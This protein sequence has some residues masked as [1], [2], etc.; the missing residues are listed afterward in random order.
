MPE[1]LRLPGSHRIKGS[2]EQF[3]LGCG[4]RTTI[5]SDSTAPT[6]VSAYDFRHRLKTF[7]GLKPMS[8][9]ARHGDQPQ[10]FIVNPLEQVPGPSVQPGKT[11]HHSGSQNKAEA[12]IPKPL[13]IRSILSTE[14]FRSPRSIPPKYVLS[15]SISRA[16]SCWLIPRALRYRRM[17]AATI[18]R[19]G[20][21]CVRFTHADHAIDGYKATGFK[22]HLGIGT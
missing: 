7:K 12:G 3:S 20:P 4:R 1:L 17:F 16:K 6:F 5:N 2:L 10:R 8:S 13:A 22:H 15:I 9:S 11:C 21:G 14:T 19:S 18:A